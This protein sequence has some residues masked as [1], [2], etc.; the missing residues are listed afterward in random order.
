MTSEREDSKTSPAMAVQIESGLYRE[1]REFCDRQG[2]RF[3]DFVADALETA[4][5]RYRTAEEEREMREMAKRV[6][7]V[8][9]E[10]F[11]RGWRHGAW[12]GYW[13]ARGDLGLALEGKAPDADGAES[14]FRTVGGGQLSLFGA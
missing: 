3:A 1:L 7:D 9:R 8:R 11:R 4:T 13:A 12:L 10:G 14:E 6:E 2:I 5:Q